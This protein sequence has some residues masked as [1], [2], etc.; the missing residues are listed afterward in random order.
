[1]SEPFKGKIGVDIRDSVP[2][3]SPVEPPRAARVVYRAFTGGTINGV[4][5]DVSGKPSVGLEREAVAMMAR[6]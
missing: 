4:A 1:M 6:E 2:N 3:W 5:A